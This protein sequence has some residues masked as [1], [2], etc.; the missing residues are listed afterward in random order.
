MGAAAF[1]IA[2]G[3]IPPIAGGGGGGA[4]RRAGGGG[5]T[6]LE[7]PGPDG[8]CGVIRDSSAMAIL[9]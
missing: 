7:E 6:G 4:G 3:I 9:L 5:G 1:G 2:G 8:G